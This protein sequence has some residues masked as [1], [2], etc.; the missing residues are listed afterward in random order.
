LKAHRFWAVLASALALACSK[1]GGR[2]SSEAGVSPSESPSTALVADAAS[3][4][5][6]ELEPHARRPPRHGG[7]IGIILR[8]AHQSTSTPEQRAAVTTIQETL[9]AEESPLSLEDY[10]NDLVAG[11]RAG[12]L[13]MAKLQADYPAIDKGVLAQQNKQAEALN[14]VHAALD[15]P[16][17][18]ATVTAARA[19]LGPIFRGRSD[20]AT[21]ASAT[22]TGG[23]DAGDGLWVKRRLA[24]ATATLG[25]DEAEQ[26]KV[27]TVL[28]KVSTPPEAYLERR[29]TIGKHSEA[30]LAAFDQDVFDAKKLDLSAAG[31]H[32]PAHEALQHEATL[33]GQVVPFLTQEQR[34]KLAKQKLHHVGRWLEEPETWSP[35][36]EPID[37]NLLR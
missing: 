29:E 22:H 18:H 19:R 3:S 10:K 12:H 26:A 7:L 8:A 30:V 24:R 15:A 33:I 11:I 37:P 35:F 20:P 16:A 25:L 36:D 5:S 9:R 6:P 1:N 28:T 27:E 32:A 14:A 31:A 34:E 21:S 17:R 2:P 4:A 23:E 13:D